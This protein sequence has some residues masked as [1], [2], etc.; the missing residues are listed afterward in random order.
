MKKFFCLLLCAG[1]ALLL[2]APACADVLYEPQDDFYERNRGDC[3]YL[4]RYFYCSGEAGYVFVYASPNAARPDTAIPN[5][6]GFFI[7]WTWNGGA[8]GVIEYDPGT[9]EASWGG[10][11][12]WV[13]LGDMVADYDDTAFSADH[14]EE[15]YESGRTLEMGR[16]QLICTWKYPGSGELMGTV[17]NFS[18]EA[19]TLSFQ[20]FFTDPLGREWGYLG[21]HYGHVDAWVCLDDPENDALAAD[22]NCRRPALI[23][24]ADETVRRA[25]LQSAAGPDFL[26]ITCA[27]GVVVIAAAVLFYTL[28][29]KKRGG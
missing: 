20:R 6:A 5:G 3:D 12:G 22:A 11:T 27:A 23:P 21:Y 9:L 1:L 26:L 17:P 14:A 19:E 18:G 2:C 4:G 10:S 8:W 13:R 7:E 16:E 25:A 28:R 24:A 15:L 29:R